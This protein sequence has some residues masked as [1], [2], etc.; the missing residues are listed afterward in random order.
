MIV[1]MDEMDEFAKDMDE[2]AN[3]VISMLKSIRRTAKDLDKRIE[4]LAGRVTCLE[5]LIGRV[6]GNYDELREVEHDTGD[7]A[8]CSS[9]D[10]G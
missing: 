7:K 9:A 5:R 1:T 8:T 4:A 10:G 2:F 3:Q 6:F